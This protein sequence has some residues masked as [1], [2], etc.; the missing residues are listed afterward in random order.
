MQVRQAVSLGD[1]VDTSNSAYD[2]GGT[3][4]NSAL[5]SVVVEAVISNVLITDAKDLNDRLDGVALGV[6]SGSD[7]RGRVKYSSG[8]P[9]TDVYVYLTHR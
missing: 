9:T 1:A 5:G 6:T 7:T 4:T 3:T 8:S 2:L